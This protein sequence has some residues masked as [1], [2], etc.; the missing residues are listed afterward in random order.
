MR[1]L[2]KRHDAEHAVQM[3]PSEA[4]PLAPA[5]FPPKESLAQAAAHDY[6][7]STGRWMSM[8]A[9]IF[10]VGL[11][12]A[13]VEVSRIKAREEYGLD[14]E[15]LRSVSTLPLVDVAVA[16]RCDERGETTFDRWELRHRGP[17][18][19]NASSAEAIPRA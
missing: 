5:D 7:K 15:T 6:P 2:K 4:D 9:L 3:L 8:I 17:H 1:M 18:T 10:A 16:K 14:Q 11:T 13:F 12:V 19:T